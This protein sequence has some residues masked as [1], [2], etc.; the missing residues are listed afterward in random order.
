MILSCKEDFS[1]RVD[2]SHG[3]GALDDV[4]GK[5]CR[6]CAEEDEPSSVEKGDVIGV[7]DRG[8]EVMHGDEKRFSFF[9]L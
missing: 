5:T 3:E 2:T 9:L 1:I 7:S 6:C 8:G 4:G